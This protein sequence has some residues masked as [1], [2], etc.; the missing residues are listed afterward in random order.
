MIGH[1][2]FHHHQALFTHG[3]S[4]L[5]NNALPDSRAMNKILQNNHEYP[6]I[7]KLN[8]LTILIITTY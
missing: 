6:I 2:A 5:Q 4:S 7:Y 8:I 1:I 3:I